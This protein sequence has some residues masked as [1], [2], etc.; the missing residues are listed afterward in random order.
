MPDLSVRKCYNALLQN[1]IST[2]CRHL[3]LVNTTEDGDSDSV[4]CLMFM[5]NVAANLPFGFVVAI[6]ELI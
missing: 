5:W 2:N 3:V 1:L 4:H 6:D